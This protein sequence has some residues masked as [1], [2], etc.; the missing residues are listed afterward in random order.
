VKP[1]TPTQPD[2]LVLGLLPGSANAA[3]A[4]APT[5]PKSTAKKAIPGFYDARRDPAIKG[6][7]GDRS[8]MLAAKPSTA[9]TDLRA[10]LGDQGIVDLDPLTGT[11]RQVARLDGFRTGPSRAPALKIATDYVRAHASLF[12]VDIDALTLRQDYVDVEGATAPKY[13]RTAR[14]GRR[15]CGTCA[16]LPAPGSPSHL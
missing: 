9:V 3:P 4:T 1:A 12:G 14:S 5:P 13:T 10:E 7:L 2:T 8:A 16:R 6:T 11:P 15:P